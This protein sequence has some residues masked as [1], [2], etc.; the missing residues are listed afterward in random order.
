MKRIILLNF[1]VFTFVQLL[2]LTGFGQLVPWRAD[3]LLSWDDFQ[4]P[5]PH[6]NYAAE[7]RWDYRYNSHYGPNGT[8]TVTVTCSFDKQKSW[9]DPKANLTAQLLLHE[10]L[11]FYVAEIFARKMRRDFKNYC[12]T[13]R[14]SPNTGKDLE[15]IYQKLKTESD[16][17]QSDYDNATNH[18]IKIDIQEEWRK[19][20]IAGLRELS[21]FEVK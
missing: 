11:H 9:K 7:T 19:K 15:Q 14:Q 5:C 1:L 3:Y 16:N 2:P 4:G 10:Q 18:G 12:A 6:N 8:I 21:E 17:Y 13:H 20:I